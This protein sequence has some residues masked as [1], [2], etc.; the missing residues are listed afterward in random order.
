MEELK[1]L[2]VAQLWIAS[3]DVVIKDLQSDLA[4]VQEVA[5][6]LGDQL[7]KAL[8]VRDEAWAYEYIEGLKKMWDHVIS[9]P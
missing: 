1:G 8:Y 3:Q 9:N 2:G 5:T 6:R 7:G 4:Q